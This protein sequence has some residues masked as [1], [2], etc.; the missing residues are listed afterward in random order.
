MASFVANAS[1]VGGVPMF[2][3]DIFLLFLVFRSYSCSYHS[4]DIRSTHTTVPQRR[5]MAT[6]F[7]CYNQL[8]GLG[9]PQSEVKL[10]GMLR[11]H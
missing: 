7:I 3:F 8:M 6:V 10:C 1:W 9:D 11:T 4:D 5:Q 2:S